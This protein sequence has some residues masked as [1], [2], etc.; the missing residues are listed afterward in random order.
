MCVCVCVCV[1]GN[2]GIKEAKIEAVTGVDFVRATLMC[3]VVISDCSVH[4]DNS[5]QLLD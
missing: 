3:G 5:V 4:D 1:A 2:D